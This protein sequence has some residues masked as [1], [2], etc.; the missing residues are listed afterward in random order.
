MLPIRTLPDLR[1]RVWGGTRLTP[2]GEPAVGEAWLA[3]GGSIVA[4]GPSDGL[5]L[6]AVAAIHGVALTGTAA[7]RS[8]RFPLLVKLLDPAEWLSV[9][10]HPDNAQARELEGPDGV[11]K[12]EAW[13]VIEAAADAQILLGVRPTATPAAVLGAVVRGGLPDL[14]ERRH[15]VAGEAYLVPAGTLHAVGPGS[16]IYEIQQPSDITY[17]ADDWSRPASSGRPLHTTQS[18]ACVV[19]T[20]WTVGVRTMADTGA[21]T[22]VACDHFVLEGLRP[23]AGQPIRRDPGLTTPHVL[24]AAAGSA[25]VR[26]SDWSE[27]L[28]PLGTLIVPADAGA[29]E[30]EAAGAPEPTVLLGRLPSLPRPS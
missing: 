1:R 7:P 27:V 2:P 4:G 5:T 22:L 3:G 21:A 28:E 13:Y 20:P 18:L 26:G 15:V 23:V 6:D 14:L 8:D 17:R 25:T 16:L 11:G 29:Y 19:P 24:T 10:V 12:T 9:Q 30:V